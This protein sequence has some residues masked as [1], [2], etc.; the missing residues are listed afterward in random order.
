MGRGKRVFAVVLSAALLIGGPAIRAYADISNSTGTNVQD[1]SNRGNSHQGGASSSGDAVGGQVTGVVSS[2]RTSVD[3]RNVSKDSSVESGDA[4]ASNS[5]DS[6]V[7][8]SSTDDDTTVGTAD[9]TFIGSGTDNFNL[10]DG[11]NR[12]T[13]NQTANATTG[14]GVAGEVIGVV[15]AAGGP[16]SVVGA[17]HPNDS[18]RDTGAADA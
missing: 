10:Q 8:Q 4:R 1:G 5:S 16:T 14:D 3:A 13:V 6:F 7:G 18:S 2:G 11:S 15:T 12:Q 9:L 17:N